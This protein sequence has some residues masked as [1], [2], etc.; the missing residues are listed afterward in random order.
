LAL[1]LGLGAAMTSLPLGD[2][3]RDPGTHDF[4][5]ANLTMGL[6]PNALP[7]VVFGQSWFGNVMDG[8][9]WSLPLEVSLYVM[10]ALV[11]LTRL[12]RVPVLTV[13]LALGVFE[14]AFDH[15]IDK[16]IIPWI[17]EPHFA[18]VAGYL[19]GVLWMLPFFAT[20]MLAYKLRDRGIFNGRLALL[21]AAVLLASVILA[22]V[23]PENALPWN[24]HRHTFIPT[25]SVCGCYLA[26]YIALHPGLPVIPA[27]RFGDL[28]Y[29][30]YIYGWPVEQTVLYLRPAATWW[31]L[32]LI[33]YPATAVVASLSWH[34]VE[35][36]ALRLKPRALGAAARPA[37]APA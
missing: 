7:G 29:G 25:F 11:G 18:S 2:Y 1:T 21:A 34:L 35:K 15:W 8:P 28:S 13:L 23:L 27:A 37:P 3:L 19:A 9:L 24:L 32:F 5:I 16:T 14:V 33:A 17:S 4:L 31:E 22:N 20:G 10:V 26:L 30:L 6:Q 12:M 36:R